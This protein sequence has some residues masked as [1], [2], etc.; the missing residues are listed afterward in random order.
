MSQITGPLFDNMADYDC[1][2]LACLKDVDNFVRM[3]ADP[4]YKEKGMP[5]HEIFAD[6]ERSK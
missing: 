4:Y 1:I 5:D 2:V 6:T 3:E